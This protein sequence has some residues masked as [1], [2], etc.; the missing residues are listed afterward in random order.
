[1][2]YE[3]LLLGLRY[4]YPTAEARFGLCQRGLLWVLPEDAAEFEWERLFAQFN[5]VVCQWVLDRARVE[6]YAVFREAAPVASLAE[7][8]HLVATMRAAGAVFHA[9]FFAC[10]GNDVRAIHFTVEGYLGA[11]GHEH[12]EV[13]L[14]TPTPRAEVFAQLTDAGV[15]LSN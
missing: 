2:N 15:P 9:P 4:L 1:M 8:L 14:L 3:D 10:R 5:P 11:K 7:I 6:H 12:F 13:R